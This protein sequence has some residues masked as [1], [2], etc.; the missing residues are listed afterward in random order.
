MAVFRATADLLFASTTTNL[1]KI[2]VIRKVNLWP[3]YLT[4][5][6]KILAN[7]LFFSFFIVKSGLSFLIS[8]CWI[9]PGRNPMLYTCLERNVKFG[10]FFRQTHVVGMNLTFFNAKDSIFGVHFKNLPF[11]KIFLLNCTLWSLQVSVQG[12]DGNVKKLEMCSLIRTTRN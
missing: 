7:Q 6:T 10:Q 5:S 11:L 9:H 8:S 1:H 2:M 4:Q 12:L 3:F